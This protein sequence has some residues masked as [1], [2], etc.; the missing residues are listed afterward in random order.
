MKI[1]SPHISKY[2]M[3]RNVNPIILTN[4][5]VIVYLLLKPVSFGYLMMQKSFPVGVV[6]NFFL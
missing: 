6:P 2:F 3:F 4:D 1:Y 5:D